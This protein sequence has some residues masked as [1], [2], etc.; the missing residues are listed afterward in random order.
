LSPKSSQPTIGP[1]RC[2]AAPIPSLTLVSSPRFDRAAQ[3]ANATLKK[4]AMNV[5]TYAVATPAM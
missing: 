5:E 3:A 2:N 1:I 4:T